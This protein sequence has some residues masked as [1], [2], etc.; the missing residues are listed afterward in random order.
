MLISQNKE[1]APSLHRQ[2]NTC[3]HKEKSYYINQMLISQNKEQTNNNT[4]TKFLK[5]HYEHVSVD[6]NTQSEN[7]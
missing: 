2:N 1:L 5:D 7:H 4:H 3:E 6:I